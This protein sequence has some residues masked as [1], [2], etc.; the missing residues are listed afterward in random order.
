M[1]GNVRN[2]VCTNCDAVN[3]VPADRP[4]EG[5]KCGKCHKALF[6]GHPR[7]V[8]AAS[9]DRHVQRNDIPV[10]VD[11]W[12]DWCGPCHAM[13]PVFERLAAESEPR[14]RFLKVD[15]D[16]APELMQRYGIR[17]IPTL[18][19]FQGGK[20][21]AQRAGAVPA[22]QLRAWLRQYVPAMA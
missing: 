8:T 21:V 6:D 20:L 17:G 11:F 7:P 22:E 4:A 15:S 2:I 13:A 12:A 1:N 10:L 3:R 5:A 16:R 14:I 9:F 18:I 19:L